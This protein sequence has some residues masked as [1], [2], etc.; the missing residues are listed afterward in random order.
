MIA[1]SLAVFDVT[2]KSL[3]S[4]AW[5]AVRSEVYAGFGSRGNR[6]KISATINDASSHSRFIIESSW[7]VSVLF[8]A[9]A[10]YSSPKIY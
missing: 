7:S 6:S 2:Y 4:I 3:F 1:V 10:I 8:D 9:R 5:T